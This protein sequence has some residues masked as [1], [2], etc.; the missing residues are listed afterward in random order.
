MGFGLLLG[1]FAGFSILWQEARPQTTLIDFALQVMIFAYSGLVA[2]FLAAIFTRRGSGASA[3]VALVV[4]FG[5]VLVMQ[6]NFATVLAFPW[7]MFI[8]TALAFGV[9]CLGRRAP[10]AGR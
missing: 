7:Q 5:A 6:W 9:C 3:V 8:A 10:I 1:L 2:V 4:G